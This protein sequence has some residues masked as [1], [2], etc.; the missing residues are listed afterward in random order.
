VRTRTSRS[1]RNKP[2]IKRAHKQPA[3]GEHNASLLVWENEWR[4]SRS[5]SQYDCQHGSAELLHHFLSFYFKCYSRYRSAAKTPCCRLSGQR[6]DKAHKKFSEL[7]S[8]TIPVPPTEI[9]AH[10]ERTEKPV[11]AGGNGGQSFPT[12]GTMLMFWPANCESEVAA[13]R[14]KSGKD[15]WTK[16]HGAL[17]PNFR[18]DRVAVLGR[19]WNW[20]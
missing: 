16:T 5:A 10:I 14:Q 20:S 2:P 1:Q 4:L 7:G 18:P 12:L 19:S 17:P 8:G 13:H 6:T 11:K 3:L 15:N 9:L